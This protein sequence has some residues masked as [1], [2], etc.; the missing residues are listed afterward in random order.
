[1]FSSKWYR[2]TAISFIILGVGLA[3]VYWATGLYMYFTHQVLWSDVVTFDTAV[4]GKWAYMTPYTLL[5]ASVW[6]TAL[7]ACSFIIGCVMFIPALKSIENKDAK[8]KKKM[9]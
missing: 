8:H 7:S 3:M 5:F 4:G 9:A 6:F 1:M 2:W